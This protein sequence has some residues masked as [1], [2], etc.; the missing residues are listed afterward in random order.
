LNYTSSP[1]KTSPGLKV[2]GRA[3][4]SDAEYYLGKLAE[5]GMGLAQAAPGS[6]EFFEGPLK[7]VQETMGFTLSV[8]YRVHSRAER[9]L[10]LEVAGVLD[11]G[12]RRPALAQGARITIDLI[13]PDPVFKNEAQAFLGRG[14]SSVN[15]PGAG[16]DIAGFV[17][18]GETA[19]SA[20]LLGG[21][22]VGAEAALQEADHR[23]FEI[24]TGLLSAM[25]LKAHFQHR[26]NHDPLTGLMNSARI[27]TELESA[28]QRAARRTNHSLTVALVDV[29]NFK[30][31]N[32]GHGHPAGDAVLGNLGRFF[33][34]ELR[35]G[36]DHAG[37]YG[38]DEFLIILEETAPDEARAILERWRLAVERLP[39][40]TTTAG[41]TAGLPVTISVGACVL[42]ASEVVPTAAEILTAADRALYAAKHAGRNC[43]S[44]PGGSAK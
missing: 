28:R 31:I 17:T 13:Q 3:A 37:R 7:I 33:A 11:P 6:S 44:A 26:A 2:P 39:R 29:D 38:G 20:Y 32:D 14:V 43:V 25:M 41:A 27:R 9:T 19:E 35:A 16:C 30:E 40:A 23:T 18:A 36:R 12:K 24:A 4:G 5:L 34:G 22:F 21:D 42:G 1:F 8:I 10:T 15:V